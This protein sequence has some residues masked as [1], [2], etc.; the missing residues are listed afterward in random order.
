MKAILLM[1]HVEAGT[2]YAIES[3]RKTFINM[4]KELVDVDDIH[5]SFTKAEEGNPSHSYEL[6]RNVIAFDPATKDKQQLNFIKS[7]INKYDISLVFGFDQP[8]WQLSY[9]YIRSGGVKAII[10]YQGAPMSSINS[11]VKL[12]LKK[13]QVLLTP[14]SPDHYIFESGAM[15]ET[16]F[17]GRGISKNNVSIVPLGVDISKFKPISDD[18]GYVYRVFKIPESQKIIYYSGHMEKRKG[19]SVLLEAAKYLYEEKGRRDFHFLILGN[20]NGEE[21][22]LLEMLKGSRALEHITFG[23]YRG[24]VHKILPGCYLGAI[25]STGWDSF[26]MSSLEISACGLPLLVSQLQGLVETIDEGKTGYSFE[27]GNYEVLASYII[28]LLDNPDLRVE[29]G[30][31]AV[32]RTRSKFTRERQVE[33]LVNVVRAV[34]NNQR[35]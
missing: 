9:R 22:S 13:L 35:C 26:T 24:D 33:S 7:Y 20:K 19:V 4:A 14:A 10:S 18:P 16:A 11:G 12:L 17:R 34:I 6:M 5:V 3:L 25:A 8:V 21:I 1:F 23:G 28:M 15:A 31:S 32:Q 29:L 2:A 30:K 27:P